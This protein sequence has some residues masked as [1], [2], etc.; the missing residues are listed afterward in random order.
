MKAKVSRIHHRIDITTLA[1]TPAEDLGPNDIAE[2]ELGLNADIPAL[3]YRSSR[4]LG[5]LVL[6]DAASQGTVAAVLVQ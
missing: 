3:P 4:A 1:H 6:V 5:S 2:I